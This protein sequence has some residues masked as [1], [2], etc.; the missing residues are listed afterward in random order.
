MP[1]V[2]TLPISISIVV[3]TWFFCAPIDGTTGTGDEPRLMGIVGSRIEAWEN[4]GL[5]I[6]YY[7][8]KA[9]RSEFAKPE[10]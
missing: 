8:R 2:I 10:A 6:A 4:A 3:M 9:Q 7:Y 5:E 1:T